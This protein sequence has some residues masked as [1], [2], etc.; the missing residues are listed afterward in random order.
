MLVKKKTHKEKL[1][2]P[3]FSKAAL[4][5]WWSLGR[6]AVD[7][8]FLTGGVVPGFTAFYLSERQALQTPATRPEN[9]HVYKRPTCLLGLKKHRVNEWAMGSGWSVCVYSSVVDGH[10]K[11]FCV[12]WP[13]V[14]PHITLR[15]TC[16]NITSTED[17]MASTVGKLYS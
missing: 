13:C 10:M 2:K 14:R 1:Q 6:Q 12:W 11:G 15:S 16:H 3:V 17:V 8:T 5:S 4:N 7:Y 9:L